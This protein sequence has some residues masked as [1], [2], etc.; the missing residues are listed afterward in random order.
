MTDSNL[1]TD[2]Y[3]FVKSDDKTSQV[4]GGNQSSDVALLRGAWFLGPLGSN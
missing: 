3:R 4:V 2:Q 1:L